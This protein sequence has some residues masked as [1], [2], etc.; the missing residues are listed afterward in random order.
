MLIGST[1]MLT[2]GTCG[3]IGGK[4]SLKGKKNQMMC[5]R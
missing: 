3:K 5:P 1:I 4:G 2:S